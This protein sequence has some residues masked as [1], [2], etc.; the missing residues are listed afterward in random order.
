MGR[1][2]SI[3]LTQLPPPNVLDYPSFETLLQ[4]RKTALIAACPEAI[5]A[6]I[7]STLQLESEPLTIDLEQ[8][9]YREL[10]LRER[11]NAAVKATFLATATGADLD[12]FAAG[13]GL[14]RK[15]IQA[16]DPD[17]T[18]PVAAILETD[19]ALRLRC[20][21]FPEKLAA[22]GPR[23]TYYAHAL[24][25]S[26]D[27][28]D[29]QVVN[30]DSGLVPA[31]TV[32]VYIK[33]HT[34]AV[35][36]SQLINMVYDYLSADSRRPLCDTVEVKAAAPLAVTIEWMNEYETGPDKAVV[37]TNQQ[38]A[39]TTLIAKNANIG[40]EVSLSKIIGALDVEG[41]KKVTL[42]KPS[43]DVVTGYGRYPVYTLKAPT[44]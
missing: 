39:I 17:A 43:A 19:A 30:A 32:R 37:F 33:S 36:S 14:V 8:S 11:I 41:V 13:R 28:A 42:L 29:A 6:T 22:A 7:A 35:A 4:E 38:A 34:A 2:V 26:T 9:V 40:A 31:G 15:V 10:I 5:R 24:D 16:A 12:Q 25:A 1:A 20:Q 23:N 44:S 21:L 3:D 27:V 18:P